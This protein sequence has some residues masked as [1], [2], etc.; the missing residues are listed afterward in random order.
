[1]N[2]PGLLGATTLGDLL[3]R[4][5]RGGV[6]GVLELVER[7]GQRA[8][9]AH[10][11]H[12]D[13]GLIDDVETELPVPRLGDVLVRGGAVEQSALG[14]IGRLVEASGARQLGETLVEQQLATAAAVRKALHEQLG[15]RLDA[16]FQLKDALVRFH[17]RGARRSS[18]ARPEPLAAGEFL[19]GRPRKRAAG[20][21]TE[22]NLSESQRSALRVLGLSPGADAAEVRLAFRKRARDA[23]PDRHPHA[24]AERRA[25]LLRR[26]AELS[27]AYHALVPTQ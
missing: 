21:A 20:R 23:H 12:F 5:Y 10:R 24:S 14:R 22:R 25:E 7:D 1:V 11:I 19:H 16:L 13:R 15:M 27:R 8:G 3:G 9:R 18:E 4:L 6:N 26:F 2:L 17:V